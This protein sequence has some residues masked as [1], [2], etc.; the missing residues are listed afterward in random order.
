[1]TTKSMQPSCKLRIYA[2]EQVFSSFI[3][4]LL[5]KRTPFEV[6]V[7]V[8]VSIPLVSQPI[9][10]IPQQLFHP[11]TEDTNM[12]GLSVADASSPEELDEL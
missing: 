12:H 1:V 7:L 10:P 3:L 5:E 2:T 4:F 8:K 6:G 11:Q 9:K